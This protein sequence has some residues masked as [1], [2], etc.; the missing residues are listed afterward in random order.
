MRP[1]HCM[2]KYD[3]E[4][5]E[6]PVTFVEVKKGAKAVWEKNWTAQIAGLQCRQSSEKSPKE[7]ILKGKFK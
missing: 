1:G 4:T 7:E 5:G 3:I 2:K 6:I